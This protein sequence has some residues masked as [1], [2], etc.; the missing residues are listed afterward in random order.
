VKY[1]P[2]CCSKV[3]LWLGFQTSHSLSYPSVSGSYLEFQY[4][5][6]SFGI[7]ADFL[8]I[9]SNGKSLDTTAFKKFLEQQKEAE[10]RQK[11]LDFTLARI[12]FP[13]ARD[14]LLGR[15]RPF[16]QFPGNLRLAVIID[17]HRE[18]YHSAKHGEKLVICTEVVQIVKVSGG[19]FL[20]QNESKDGWE[21]VGEF[22]ACRKVSHGFR[23]LTKR[24]APSQLAMGGGGLFNF[25]PTTDGNK[26]ARSS[27]STETEC[28]SNEMDPVFPWF[29]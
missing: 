21:E 20:E 15:G 17:L 26:R 23:T 29:Q 8:P 25:A 18:R 19:R 2:S 7:P 11:D 10:N 28:G 16:Q 5:L 14:V 27:P 24:S 13:L 4:A 12:N 3:F 1:F 22:I 9:A 6:K